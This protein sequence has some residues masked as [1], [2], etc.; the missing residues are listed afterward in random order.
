[1]SGDL[2]DADRT[3]SVRSHPSGRSG[4]ARHATG[5]DQTSNETTMA[6]AREGTGTRTAQSAE[7]RRRSH[8][9][10]VAAATGAAV[11]VG[12]AV[13]GGGYRRRVAVVGLAFG[14]QIGSR[15]RYVVGCSSRA[16]RCIARGARFRHELAAAPRR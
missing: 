4:G 10:T 9:G 15:P 3:A 12:W 13:S 16:R 2:S 7:E 6:H 8:P 5:A 11:E 1:G 14:G